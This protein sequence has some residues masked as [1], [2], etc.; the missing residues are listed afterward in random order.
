MIPTLRQ[1][2]VVGLTLFVASASA[3]AAE[4]VDTADN[5]CHDDAVHHDCDNAADC[6]GNERA[7][8]CVEHEPGVASS[9]RCE[10]PCEAG[11]GVAVSA[12]PNACAVGETC[13]Q[14][15]ASPSRKAYWCKPTSFR[16]DLNLLD[17]CVSHH[18]GGLQPSLSENTCSLEANLT[19]LLDQ[20]GDRTFDIFDLDLCILAFLEQPTCDPQA[21]V[22]DSDDQVACRGDDDCGDGLYCSEAT[23]ACQRDCGIVA[24]REPGLSELERK[25][26]GQGKVCDF[27]RGR[28]V[29]VDVTLAT[30]EVDSQC[31]AGAY[32]FLGHCAPKCYRSAECPSA[33]WFCTEN[34]R[35]RS[36]PPPEAEGGFVFDPQNY[37]IRFARDQMKLDAV[38]T[39]E[40]SALV[41]LDLLTKQQVVDNPSVSFGYRL[42]LSYGMK[43]DTQCL[44]PFVDC[45][46]A[47]QRAPSESE[48]ACRARQD[49]CYV[50]DT[51]QWVTLE[52]PFGVVAAQSDS[53][54]GIRLDEAAADRLSPG[55]YQATLRAIFDNG[56]SHSIQVV[57][58]K[59][60]PSGEYDGRVT[61]YRKVIDNAINPQSA[62][63]F[64]MRIK[65]YDQ[66]KR[67]NELL[68]EYNLVPATIV[69]D[70][71][72]FV[73]I[74]RG[75][76]VHGMLHGDDGMPFAKGDAKSTATNEIPFV[77]I[78]SPDLGRMRVIGVIDLAGD[79]CIASDGRP[80]S[81]A[82]RTDGV[83]EV[84]SPFG[85]NIRRVIELIGP[86]DDATGRFSGIYREKISRLVNHDLTLEGGFILD[87]VLA[88]ASPLSV[89]PASFELDVPSDSFALAKS[90]SQ[91][92]IATWCGSDLDHVYTA[93]SGLPKTEVDAAISDFRTYLGTVAASATD[94]D[95]IDVESWALTVDGDV[96]P[97]V[98]SYVRAHLVRL[99][100]K[101]PFASATAFASY[102][103][104]AKRSGTG[105]AASPTGRTTV[106]PALRE[107]KDNVFDALQALG[108]DSPQTQQDHLSIY[109]F[110]SP[111]VLPCVDSAASPPPMCIDEASVRCGLAL[112]RKAVLEGWVPGPQGLVGNGYPLF[113]SDTVSL[114]GCPVAGQGA[115]RPFAL[116]EHNRFWSDRMQIDKFAADRARSDAFL[117]LFRHETNPFLTSPA[118]NYKLE[119]LQVSLA[120]YDGMLAEI[121]GV[122]GAWTLTSIDV[123]D[124]S[125][126]GRD[127]LDLMHTI[128]SDRMDTLAELIDVKRRLAPTQASPD[129]IFADHLMQYTYLVEVFLMEL[130]AQWEGPTFQYRGE[131]GSV[132]ASG[133]SLLNQLRPPRNAIGV[134]P[135]Q[136][137]FE[138]NSTLQ[139]N[140]QHYREEVGAFVDEVRDGVDAAATNLTNA[141]L[142]LDAFERSLHDARK[143]L[144]QSLDQLCGDP[145]PGD[146]SGATSNYCQYLLKQ[147]SGQDDFSHVLSC[148]LAAYIDELDAD[149][150]TAEDRLKQYYGQSFEKPTD[151]PANFAFDSELV[152]LGRDLDVDVGDS[153]KF[154][155]YGG[156]SACAEVAIRFLGIADTSDGASGSTDPLYGPPSC[157]LSTE[158]AWLDVN[159]VQRPCVGGEMGAL[160]QEKADLDRQRRLVIHKVATVLDEID[161][162]YLQAGLLAAEDEALYWRSQTIDAAKEAAASIIG[163]MTEE[164][165]TADHTLEAVKCI[166]IAGVA[167]GTDCFTK[168]TAAVAQ[169]TKDR[170][171]AVIKFAL[172]Q[173]QSA[174]DKVKSDLEHASGL[175]K[176]AIEAFISLPGAEDLV[177]EYIQLTQ[178][179]FNLAA[180]I[181]DK[182]YQAQQVVRLYNSDI[183]FVA[184]HLSGRES[185][186]QVLGQLQAREADSR[187]RELVRYLYRLAMAFVHHFNLP[188]AEASPLIA[189]AQ[190]VSTLSDVASFLATID[191]RAGTYCG[192]AGL[193][194]DYATNTETLRV[195][196][197]QTLFPNLRDIVDPHTGQVVTAGQQF[198]NL[199]TRPPFLK[200]R[201]RGGLA[202]DQ[203]ELPFAVS[204]EPLTNTPDGSPRW[205]VDPLS[206]NHLIDGRDPSDPT[207]IDGSDASA[208][209]SGSMAV[210]V[211]GLN[212]DDPSR[213][214]RYQ[215]VRGSTDFL[216][217]CEAENVTGAFGTVPKVDYPVRK[218]TVGYAPQ[219]QFASQATPP[220]YYTVSPSYTA[221]VNTGEALGTLDG[222]Y[223]WRYHARDRSLAAP[224]WKLV[225][226]LEIDG[227]ST[228][229]AWIAQSALGTDEAPVVED[230]VV[231]FRY[232]SRPIQE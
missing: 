76:L 120:K 21:L 187:F 156:V 87:Q 60:S 94:F 166:L 229:S 8:L 211:L 170:I 148:K 216:R 171:L 179:S 3:R 169:T 141:L 133:Q 89:T 186:N 4:P 225:I 231:Y 103:S 105:N 190:S 13:V 25:C 223:C 140:W 91:T 68:R 16:V 185:G 196:L 210:N 98:L 61:I 161:A 226:P 74:T 217:S 41:I 81:N 153:T 116:Q 12:E 178:S 218:H 147:F 136:V 33:D 84:K 14:G 128:V 160:L 57:Y 15:R 135:G 73:D 44:S 69:A 49:D 117:V 93:D 29:A 65:V 79:F 83:I 143:E 72:G 37:A 119:Q 122:P 138:N 53:A 34:N 28:C 195:S 54:I 5:L 26:M 203:I 115:V 198:H 144:T 110:L 20:N 134:I 19:A 108:A 127:W 50:D 77:G 6:A 101:L 180:L 145:D 124:F 56:D 7:T 202:T 43:L 194:C 219:S 157:E 111:Y 39:T 197:R 113:C 168:A 78:Y 88:D 154:S 125:G 176:A 213:F 192:L 224:D 191:T 32:C 174:L 118:I 18:L 99:A 215:M 22:C 212:I 199:I 58:S 222:G 11:T 139:F 227:A 137:Y 163:L 36:L 152:C 230:I 165:K 164:S 132:F 85:R 130:Q 10:N 142:D 30:C 106:L 52:S 177:A 67:W 107:F 1:S 220:S 90:Q 59:M 159:G 86:F 42:E 208:S 206:C 38:Q 64:G 204:L 173:I 96:A 31:P 82:N 167:S 66:Y 158:Q 2:A 80:C 207:G 35:C 109:D 193:D 221:C 100:A 149:P 228:D 51:E 97:D 40:S 123:S 112:H 48:D 46:D 95:A 175:E 200:R 232:R 155:A 62:F 121:V 184:E 183:T 75:L 129:A 24:S 55:T 131:S 104:A 151:C 205:L 27:A 181:E 201:V 114:S 70:N 209:M 188:P 63:P 92:D 146:P 71:N 17:Q 23:H 150:S 172:E 45:G 162:A 126:R 102:I 189:E 47:S 214:V 182:R 9:R